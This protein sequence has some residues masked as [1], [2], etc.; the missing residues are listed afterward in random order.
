MIRIQPPITF[1]QR[2]RF[3][4]RVHRRDELRW[5]MLGQVALVVIELAR[6][7]GIDC[8]KIDEACA[9]LTRAANELEDYAKEL[10]RR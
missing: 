5:K 10:E 7:A 9:D 4:A 8:S 1:E 2:Q 6:R 3:N